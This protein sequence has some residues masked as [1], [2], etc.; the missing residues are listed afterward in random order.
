MSPSLH[1]MQGVCL[2]LNPLKKS[3]WATCSCQHQRDPM[4]GMCL[5]Q[6]KANSKTCAAC[7]D[8]YQAHPQ[9]A[10][11]THP[12]CSDSRHRKCST[13]STSESGIHSHHGPP[14]LCR[15]TLL[16]YGRQVSRAK[17]AS[18]QASKQAKNQL[19]KKASQLSK[20]SP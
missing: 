2:S 13:T 15:I 19:S 9:M 16:G 18:E 8:H 1:S 11:F 4:I 20:R 12:L 5:P 6:S 17:Q 14:N 7:I 10:R 3:L